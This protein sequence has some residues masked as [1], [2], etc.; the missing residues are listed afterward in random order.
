MVNLRKIIYINLGHSKWLDVYN[1]IKKNLLK[2][3][4]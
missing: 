1:L 2:W 3:Q 4:R